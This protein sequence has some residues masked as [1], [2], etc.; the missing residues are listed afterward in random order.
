[1][2][3][4]ASVRPSGNG[5][6]IDISVSPNSDR[7]GLDGYDPWRKR[8]IV[9]VSAQPQDGKANAEVVSTMSS[10]TGFPSEIIRGHTSRQK[11][12]Y[13]EG[14]LEEVKGRLAEHVE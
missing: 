4:L 8:I 7:P 11:T 12:V 5:A 9:R 3:F 14:P 6:E 1:M 10:V 2:E 13:V